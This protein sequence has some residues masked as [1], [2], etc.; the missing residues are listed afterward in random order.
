[1]AYSRIKDILENTVTL[2]FSPKTT[3]VNKSRTITGNNIW[4]WLTSL[5]NNIICNSS[6]IHSIEQQIIINELEK[7]PKA[8]VM[9]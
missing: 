5:F 9:D 4:H 1:V 8:M 6:Y 3:T 2:Y 7:M